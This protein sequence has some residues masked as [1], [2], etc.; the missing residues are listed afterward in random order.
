MDA[1]ILTSKNFNLC[2]RDKGLGVTGYWN[3]N[4]ESKSN[5][6]EIM[7]EV[8]ITTD[9]RGGPL[10]IPCYSTSCFITRLENPTKMHDV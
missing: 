6:S 5:Q 1:T 7:K 3:T 10:H 8:I 4:K 9:L 2:K